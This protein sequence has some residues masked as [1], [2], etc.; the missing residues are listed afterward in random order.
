MNKPNEKTF[1]IDGGAGRIICSIPALKKYAKLNPNSNFNVLV[2]GHDYLFWGIKELQNKV[3]NSEQKGLFEDVIKNSIVIRPE[4][5]ALWSYYN[6]KKS[7]SQSFDEIINETEDHS[8]LEIPKL[9]LSKSEELNGFHVVRDVKQK[10][11]KNKTIVI[12]PFGQGAKN[13]RGYILDEETRSFEHPFYLK[14]TKKLSEKYNLIL[15]SPKEF[16]IDSDKQTFKLE[17]DLRNWAGIINA[18]DYFIGC[19]SVGQHLARGFNKKGSVILGST[20]AINTSYP[21]WF[22]IIEKKNIYKS[23]TPIRVL[24]FDSF[25]ANKINDRNMDFD[26]KEIDEIY[27]NIVNDIEKGK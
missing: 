3:K 4:P 17:T 8:D 14:L 18:S 25:M 10:Y 6:Q 23:Y 24:G 22:N 9:I 12:Q 26:E 27:K 2:W 11:G 20:F 1:M 19:D 5:Y 16:Y 21:D 15:F 13:D 7:L